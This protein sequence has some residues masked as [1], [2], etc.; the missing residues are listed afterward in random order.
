MQLGIYFCSHPF[1]GSKN[2]LS[3]TEFNETSIQTWKIQCLSH[4]IIY[5]MYNI[6]NAPVYSQPIKLY[7]LLEIL[8]LMLLGEKRSM[9]SWAGRRM[10]CFV[11]AVHLLRGFVSSIICGQCLIRLYYF[12]WLPKTTC[13]VVLLAMYAIIFS[14]STP[15]F[16]LVVSIIV[17]TSVPGSIIKLFKQTFEPTY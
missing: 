11:V 12:I 17:S 14:T 13:K 4:T 5:N 15:N 3:S 9:R 1:N 7:I 8:I 2:P 10:L 6:Y 16:S